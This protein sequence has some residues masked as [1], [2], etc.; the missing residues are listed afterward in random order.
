MAKRI[1]QV[2]VGKGHGERGPR[3]VTRIFRYN[4]GNS[5]IEI[6]DIRSFF[7]QHEIVRPR[8]IP[9]FHPW[10]SILHIFKRQD[11]VELLRG[12]QIWFFKYPRHK[13]ITFVLEADRLSKQ[14]LC[15][16]E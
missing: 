12:M 9:A 6:A 3:G 11:K 4:A 7:Q 10:I 5:L 13:K 1:S 2:T 16:P 14:P 15:C 8:V